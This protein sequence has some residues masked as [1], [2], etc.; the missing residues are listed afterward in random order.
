MKRARRANGSSAPL[1]PEQ[2][3]WDLLGIVRPML[4]FFAEIDDVFSEDD[5]LLAE[6]RQMGLGR[7]YRSWKKC[8]AAMDPDYEPERDRR[9]RP[10]R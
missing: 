9:D 2:R 10:A 7:C 4:E 3:F 6:K 1:T 8:R 5:A